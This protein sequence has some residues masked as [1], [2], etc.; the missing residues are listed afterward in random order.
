[1]IS[2]DPKDL[3]TGRLHGYL[4]STVAPRPIAFASTV[5]AEGN[6]NL[7]PFSFFNVFSANPPIM[8]FSPARRVRDNSVK[9]TLENVMET[10]EVVI[11]VVNYDMVHQ[12]SLS[13]TDYPKGVNEFEKAGFTMLK[14]DKVKPF[15]VAESPVQFECKVNDIIHLGTEGGAGN[16][17]ICEVVKLHITEE[18]LDENSIVIQEKLDLVARAGADYY[19]RAKKGF[20]EIPKPLRKLGIGIDAMPLEIRNSMILTGNDLG[21]LG[22]VEVLPTSE[23]I[24]E[25]IESIS[26]RYPNIKE[27]SH[28]QKHK[29]AHNYLSYGDVASAWKLLLS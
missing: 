16:L 25:F 4:L 29:I 5:D 15:R 17:V 2:F 9:H 7:S 13:S 24:N 3:S 19:N 6:P 11:N 21:M 8:I 12:A 18:I 1:M 27:M 20:F 28:R 14:S 23:Q 26:E 22:N 10:R